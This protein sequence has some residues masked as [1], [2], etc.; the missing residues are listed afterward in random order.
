MASSKPSAGK[1]RERVTLSRRIAANPDAPDD[2]G[3]VESH[4]EDL[5]TVWAEYIHLKGGEA[6]IAGR[7][8]GRHPL[9]IRLRA[10][11]FSREIATDWRVIDARTGTVFAI[12][13]VTHTPDRAW[14]ELLA[15]SGVAA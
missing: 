7:L 9:V 15:E 12:K 3:N 2:L 14:I 6:I 10:S 5:C 1:M 8:Q 13:D 11:S 4:W